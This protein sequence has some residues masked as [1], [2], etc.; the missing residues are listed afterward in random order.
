MENIFQV[1]A[2]KRC[3]VVLQR[4]KNNLNLKHFSLAN[5]LAPLQARGFVNDCKIKNI[6]STIWYLNTWNILE[7]YL[8]AVFKSFFGSGFGAEKPFW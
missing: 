4:N 8:S 6:G 5:S 3:V 2:T 1:A 7:I